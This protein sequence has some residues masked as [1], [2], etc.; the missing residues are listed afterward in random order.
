MAKVFRQYEN[1]DIILIYQPRKN[2]MTTNILPESDE[3]INLRL[4]NRFAALSTMTTACTQGVVRSLIVSGKP[5]VG[6]SYNVENIL[7]NL[8]ERLTTSSVS[9]FVRAT[10]LFKLL[11]ENKEKGCTIVI[12]DCDSI[13]DDVTCLNLLKSATDTKDVRKITWG[14][15]T[16]FETEDGEEL[17]RSFEF[18]GTVIILTNIDIDAAS[19]ASNKNAVHISAML[20]RSCYIDLGLN[21]NRALFLHLQ[22]VVRNGM[23]SNQNI[24]Y[25]V[26]CDL[27]HFVESNLEELRE[28]SLRTIM[29]LAALIRIDPKGWKILAQ[30]VVMK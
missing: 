23:L 1:C 28:I 4:K 16:K 6:K 9:G 29:K 8:P 26:E 30:S 24:G 22:N 7:R 15:E 2:K 21:S 3:M 5:G 27:L 17:P 20:S 13:F 10:G 11:F 14:S 12:D 25:D 18:H 19:R